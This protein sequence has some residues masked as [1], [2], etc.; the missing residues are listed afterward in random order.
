MFNITESRFYKEEQVLEPANGFSI[1]RKKSKGKHLTLMHRF[2]DED[3]I[4]IYIL[5]CFFPLNSVIFKYLLMQQLI[6]GFSQ[7]KMAS[8]T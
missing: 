6:I 1:N 3:F 2:I 7:V 8:Q 4:Y 5:P